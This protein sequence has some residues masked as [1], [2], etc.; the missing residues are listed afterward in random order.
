MWKYIFKDNICQ[1]LL[2]VSTNIWTFA[3][4]FDDRE[5]YHQIWIRIKENPFK[6]SFLFINRSVI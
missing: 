4:D 2:G 6:N 1:I 3:I 5:D